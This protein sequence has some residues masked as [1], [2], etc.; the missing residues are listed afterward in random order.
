MICELI[1]TT[2]ESTAIDAREKAP[3]ASTEDMYNKTGYQNSKIGPLS[4]GVPG[5]LAGYWHMFQNHRSGSI[6]W[7]RLFTDV[8]KLCEEGFHVSQHLN[9]ALI[10]NND[11]IMSQKSLSDIY[12]NP[13]TNKTYSTG[14][15]L[16]QKQLGDTLRKISEADNPKD[17]FYKTLSQQIVEDIKKSENSYNVTTIITVEDF[18]NYTIEERDPVLTTNL[19]GDNITLHTFPLPGQL[20]IAFNNYLFN[21]Y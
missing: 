7:K 1:A 5:E 9:D 21:Y 20:I 8:I 19:R 17:F 10:Q 6:E 11:I 4:I 3:S 2:G 13:N 15:L 18:M 12:V 14:E 16:I